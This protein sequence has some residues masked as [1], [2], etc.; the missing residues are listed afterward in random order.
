MAWPP[1]L[2]P[3]CSFIPN[4]EAALG[5]MTHVQKVVGLNPSAIYWIDIFHIDWLQKL[6]CLFEK[7]ENKLKRGRGRPIFK[8]PWNRT[9]KAKWK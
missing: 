9:H 1:Y 3:F 6:Y 7:T 8:K 2:Y 5:G 4:H